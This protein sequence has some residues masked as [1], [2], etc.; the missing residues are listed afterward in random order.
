MLF[1]RASGIF[2]VGAV[3]AF[4]VIVAKDCFLFLIDILCLSLL[5]NAV[6]CVYVREYVCMLRPCAGCVC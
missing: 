2:V 4:V 5:T 6:A 1:A 3:A